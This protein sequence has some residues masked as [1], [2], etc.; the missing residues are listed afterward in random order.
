MFW[1]QH[2][3]WEGSPQPQGGPDPLWPTLVS[4]P[5][6]PWWRHWVLGMGVRTLVSWRQNGMEA[7]DWLLENG[8]KTRIER[9]RVKGGGANCSGGW[10]LSG[11]GGG[12]KSIYLSPARLPSPL[13]TPSP[14][15]FP[16]LLCSSPLL[17]SSPF[18]TII[19]SHTHRQ[20]AA[21]P[22]LISKAPPCSTAHPAACSARARKGTTRNYSIIYYKYSKIIINIIIIQLIN[23]T[24]CSPHPATHL[25]W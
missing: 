25:K 2:E 19:T 10:G 6:I 13:L 3:W 8:G 9:K 7:S 14:S 12:G 20:T 18:F 17:T 23:T 15:H 16:L 22:T 5:Q 21:A 1:P 11:W 24:S 4:A